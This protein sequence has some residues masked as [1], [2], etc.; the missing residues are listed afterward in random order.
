M[1][2]YLRLSVLFLTVCLVSFW[3]RSE[4]VWA[5]KDN[6]HVVRAGVL[7]SF[8]PLYSVNDS[9]Q[10][11][12]FAV[13]FFDA[14]SLFAGIE[15]EY[16][17]FDT[18]EEALQALQ[19]NTIDVIPNM[20]ITP[21]R[22]KFTNYTDSYDTTS[23]SIFVRSN[24]TSISSIEDLNSHRVGVVVSNIGANI[25][26]QYGLTNV[27]HYENQ[28]DLFIHLLSGHIDAAIFIKMFFL[29]TAT[30]SG[31]RDR[32]KVVGQPLLEM[33]RAI[34]VAKDEPELCIFLNNKLN[35]F[36][37]TD[38]FTRIYTK[39]HASEQNN[40]YHLA[41][42]IV[43]ALSA[44]ALLL[45]GFYF[46]RKRANR[47]RRKALDGEKRYKHL[48]RE[49]IAGAALHEIIVDEAGKPI[50]YT[51]LDVNPEFE[52]MTGLRREDIINKTVLEVLHNT[53]AV[54]IEKYGD[55]A[56]TGVP[57]HF[58]SYSRE[59]DK[60]FEVRAYC[61]Q[62][63]QFAVIF[64]DVTQERKALRALKDSEE[65][66]RHIIER[67]PELGVSLKPDGT[68]VFVNEYL[69]ELTMWKREDLL[70]KNWFDLFV[71]EDE[72]AKLKPVHDNFVKDQNSELYFSFENEIVLKDGTRRRIAWSNVMLRDQTGNVFEVACL[73]TDMTSKMKAVEEANK[74]S[75]AKSVFL[76]N[77]SHEVRTP[78]NGILG[79]LQLLKAT[80]LESVQQTYVQVAVDAARRLTRLLSDIIDLSKIEVGIVNIV[81][82]EF[83]VRV[84][85]R[86]TCEMFLMIIDQE[87]LELVMHIDERIPE[88]IIGDEARLR[89]ILTNIL[90]NAVKYT[91]KGRIEFN[92]WL[93]SHRASHGMRLLFEV[94][95]TGIGISD[96]MFG[97]V[98]DK[99]TQVD[100][101]FTRRFQGAGLGL[102]IVKSLV[103][104]MGG[105][106][107]I[108]SELGQGTE[109]RVSIPFR[110][111][112]ELI[113]EE[114]DALPLQVH[115]SL[116]VLVCE[117]DDVN[118]LTLREMLSKLGHQ[119][120][121][122][123]NGM[124]AL[125]LLRENT[126][127]MILMD[128][129]MPVLNGVDAT[130]H[131]RTDLEFAEKA[132]IPIIAITAYAMKTDKDRFLEAG[133]DD[134]L[135]KPI[136]F[137]ELAAMV[138]RWGAQKS[139]HA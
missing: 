71:P 130:K 78:M 135:A 125:E 46:Y 129:Q 52:R 19:N 87:A 30:E 40:G 66:F 76:A 35:Q 15:R 33:K 6:P 13:E 74:A 89:Q 14:F 91:E 49:M 17:L 1:G 124:G 38:A 118:N 110:D 28:N 44:S 97:I 64:V 72:L 24:N 29:R 57:V 101:S 108:A 54:W 58:E 82:E 23:I 96:D 3:C 127:H 42:I 85:A 94:I 128:I 126:Y 133:M 34:G 27:V 10:I 103:T 7:R 8:D 2:P 69:L 83:D 122:A 121:S 119:V 18:W 92:I 132:S 84:V 70:G 53:E 109:L 51:F 100:T 139:Q 81:E 79:M 113:T 16:I 41:E 61:P 50:D 105:N 102:S 36:I 77:M 22:S 88:K 136:E 90:G 137:T 12:G 123:S 65:R 59:L 21:A 80:P 5:Q 99:F 62:R 93:V 114:F 68:I 67:I 131:I 120:D 25:A 4:T 26:E 115:D 138:N 117:D 55:V 31:L 86:E 107:S 45:F 39:W 48:F 98:F 116:R 9:G 37:K 63:G 104:A 60:Y 75:L 106:I 56:L 95:D 112:E 43:S 47:L 73:G 134:Y 11:T 20:G 111:N 32:I